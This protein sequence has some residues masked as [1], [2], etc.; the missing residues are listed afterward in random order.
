MKRLVLLLFA[1]VMMSV[2]AL[3]QD[4]KTFENKAFSIS[5]PSDWE[6]TYDTDKCLN[7]ENP[8]GDIRFDITF[9]MEGPMKTQLQ[10]TVDNWVYMKESRGHK[11][12][13]TMVKDDYALVRSIETNE[14][15]G[16]QTVVVWFLMISS[17]PQCFCGT[18]NSSYERANEAANLLVKMLGTL[19][20]K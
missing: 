13:Q 19:N 5:Y 3:A 8:D 4:L 6:V 11:V 2:A 20:P 15:D 17:E 14:Y 12:D 7:L 18:I 10:E 1:S 16:T 9:S